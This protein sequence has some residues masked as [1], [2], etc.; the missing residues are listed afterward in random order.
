MAKNTNRTRDSHV[1]IPVAVAAGTVSGDV[2][3]LG[4]A[5]LT[6]YAVTDRYVAA[7][8]DE[9]SITAP[10]QG[11]ADGEAS[12]EVI[13]VSRVVTLTVAGGVALGAAIYSDGAGG[14]DGTS[15]TEV[16]VGYALE[17]ITAAEAGLVGLARA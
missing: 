16:F 3:A 14:Y 17:A 13:G 9:N 2:I 12:V 5:G 7:D 15:T 10:P 11:L 8:Y 4:A 1:L 6:G